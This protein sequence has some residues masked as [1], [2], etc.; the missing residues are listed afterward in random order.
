AGAAWCAL[1]IGLG[2][3]L[4]ESAKQMEK[5]IG[6]ASWIVLGVLVLGF[7]AFLLI[8]RTRKAAKAGEV[9]QVATREPEP[10]R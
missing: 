1:H 7:V 8:K 10:Q 3:A 5:H 6:N 9:E 2:A 4:G